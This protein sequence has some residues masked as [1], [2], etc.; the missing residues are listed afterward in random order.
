VRA[1]GLLRG[2]L[3]LLRRG[4]PRRL[5]ALDLETTGY[6]A[7]HAEV[8]AI[9]T[10]PIV[11]GAV[12]VGATTSTLV[13]PAERS[14]VEGIGAHHLRPSDVTDAPRLAEVL[15]ELLDAIAA[16]DALLVHHAPLDVTVLRRACAATGVRWPAPPVIDTVELIR[17]VRARERA[18][19]AGR[20]TPRDLGGARA[21]LGL[22]PHR[23]HDAA[24][25]AIAT[26]ELY[27]ALCAR[28][29]R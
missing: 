26:A 1:T 27:L 24:A 5:L 2:R 9:G 7:D 13:R 22:P 28:L 12:Q 18:T 4:G 29:T 17:R 14:A 23:A 15:P 20:R 8:L 3:T 10:V 6:D 16:V 19:G 11:D 21:A 25:D